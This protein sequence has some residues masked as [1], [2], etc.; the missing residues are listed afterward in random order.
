MTDERKKK[1]GRK[2]ENFTLIELLIVIAIIAI[3]AAMLLPALSKARES[4]K[5]IHCLSNTRQIG[6]AFGMYFQDYND[7][8]PDGTCKSDV[9]V[10][11]SWAFLF[12]QYIGCN[13]KSHATESYY[14]TTKERPKVFVCPKDECKMS[15]LT[16][17]L[18]YGLNLHITKK[19]IK[20]VTLPS[21][22]L[23]VTDSAFY[24]TSHS[25]SSYHFMVQPSG[26]S[27]LLSDPPEHNSI[28][29]IRKHGNKANVLFIAGNA[30]TLLAK[31]IAARGADT[32]GYYLPW[33]SI[34]GS[35]GWDM[36]V[37]PK[38]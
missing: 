20:N 21:K 32:S 5:N 3:L 31:Q 14:L 38:D 16:H 33:G 26:M 11:Q 28:P 25:S 6:A 23:L 35:G 19:T 1:M 27:A 10:T 12:F 17:H 22:R 13:A 37:N 4:A 24:P 34:Y 15:D 8:I 2:K 30:Q 36:M 18:G 9:G 7:W 29:G